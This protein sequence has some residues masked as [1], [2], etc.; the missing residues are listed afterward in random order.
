MFTRLGLVSIVF[1][2]LA[3]TNQPQIT[4]TFGEPIS[5]RKPTRVSKI[6]AQPESYLGQRVLVRGK[7]LEVCPNK[8]CWIDIDSDAP[9]EKI[10]V[11]V[12]DD[13]IVFPQTLK[14][15]TVL[16]EGV[17]EKLQLSKEQALAMRKHEAEEYG[18]EFDPQ[19]EVTEETIYRIK[20]MGAAVV[21]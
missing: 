16:V 6:L 21:N 4:E 11:K 19:I 2:S 5:L 13:I 3:C 17:V 15:Q 18:K 1:V 7:V 14:G 20:G 10:Q 8:G 9:D 12:E